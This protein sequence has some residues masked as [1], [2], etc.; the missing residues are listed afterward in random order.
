MAGEIPETPPNSGENGPDEPRRRQRRLGFDA[1]RAG[2]LD[3]MRRLRS[4]R[5]KETESDDED[6]E[7]KESKRS[8]RESKKGKTEKLASRA[9]EIVKTLFERTVV[10]PEPVESEKEKEPAPT[11]T[12]PAASAAEAAPAVAQPPEQ[13]AERDTA[14]APLEAKAEEAKG[15]ATDTEPNPESDEQTGEIPLHDEPQDTPEA[16]E[17]TVPLARESNDEEEPQP[18]DRRVPAEAPPVYAAPTNAAAAER[19]FHESAS[20]SEPERVIARD[21][22]ARRMAAVNLVVTGME[23]IGRHSADRKINKN[24]ARVNKK[25]DKAQ[26]NLRAAEQDAAKTRKAAERMDL[27]QQAFDSRRVPERVQVL[28]KKAADSKEQLK[29]L[30][31]AE[32]AGEKK[33]VRATEQ[34]APATDQEKKPT[35]ETAPDSEKQ[36]MER[37]LHPVETHTR[38]EAMLKTVEVAAQEN[39]PLERLYEQR[40]ERKDESGSLS[41]AGGVAAAAGSQ[42]APSQSSASSVAP[43]QAQPLARLTDLSQQIPPM[44]RQ[45]AKNGAQGAGVVLAVLALVAL[46]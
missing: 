18:E 12:T 22:Q 16:A 21:P 7:K 39:V 25:V 35:M 2:L 33:P 11:E 45:A 41:D 28:E 34:Q 5:T 9:R 8:K 15:K 23:S 20:S 10:R 6:D 31:A 37:L 27:W 36:R 13:P 44:Y 38:P 1:E 40:H 26:E 32:S 4:G 43:Q 17:H 29:T 14:E 3:L 24:L 19:S 42:A 30:V 46:L